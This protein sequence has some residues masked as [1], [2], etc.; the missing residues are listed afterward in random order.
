MNINQIV[1]S[2]ASEFSKY[3]KYITFATVIAS[4]LVAG[5]A[6]YGLLRGRK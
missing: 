1:D 4:T 3:S 2:T 6:I 5:V